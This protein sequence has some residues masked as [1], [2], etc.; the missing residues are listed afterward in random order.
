MTTLATAVTD[1]T[2]AAAAVPTATGAGCTAQPDPP[3]AV[4]AAM[5]GPTRVPGAATIAGGTPIAV[6]LSTATRTLTKH[7]DSPRLDAEVLL[8]NLLGISRTALIVHAAEP[9]AADSRAAFERLIARRVAGTPVAYLTGRREFWSLELCVTADVLVP[10]P[11]T[12][13]L[14]EVALAL[15]PRGPAAVLDLGTGS[16]AVALAIASERPLARVIGVDVSAPALAV[17]IANSRKLGLSHIDWR[18][19]SW[20]EAVAGERFDLI[21]ANPPYVAA[22]DP[23]LASLAAEPAIA[24]SSGP[25][26]LEALSAIIAGA[27]RYLHTAGRL[28]LEHGGSQAA[29]VARLLEHRGFRDI[30]SRADYSGHLR[31]TRATVPGSH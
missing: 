22:A 24:L 13:I 12:E 5:S 19:G 31:V 20:F 16:G 21:V 27:A 14:V 3:N 4:A 29:D 25:T 7:S 28:I 10:R 18:L 1:D 26:G 8:A 30:R 9:I 2:G 23:A 15:L 11:E 6:A 17:A